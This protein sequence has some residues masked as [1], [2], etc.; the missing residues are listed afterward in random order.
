MEIISVYFALLSIVSIFIFYLL[1]YKYRIGFLAI[2][3]CSFIASIDYL[4]LLYIII[5][6]LINYFIGIKLPNSKYKV[7]L[8]RT[9]IIVNLSQLILL[10]YASFTV[11]PL[12]RLFNNNIQ[13]SKLT[14]ILVPIGISYFTLQG[15]GYLINIKRGWEKPEKKLLDFLLY[16]TFFPKFLSGPIE[17]SNHFLPQLKSAISFNE[18]QVSEGLKIALFGFFKKVVIANQLGRIVFLAHSDPDSF[19]LPELWLVVLIQPLYLYFDF[20]GYTDIARGFAKTFGIDLL[21]NF[22]KPFL[23]ENMTGFWKRFHMSL[24]AWFNDYVFNPISFKF[25]RWGKSAAVFALFVS[26][27]LFGI[28]HGAGWNFMAL[29]LAQAL[30]I[31]YEFFTKRIRSELGSKIPAFLRVMMSRIITFIFYGLS[32][33][34]FFSRDLNSSLHFFSQLTDLSP[35]SNTKHL[36]NLLFFAL[37]LSFIFL[38]IDYLKQD[39]TEINNRIEKI[40][41]SSR[42]F[43]LSV[44]YAVAFLIL[45]FIGNKLTFVYQ[46]F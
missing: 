5:Y 43:R 33:I 45:V 44:Y 2:L 27:T 39:H 24:S 40:F 21:P 26:W 38:L 20:S 29:G 18:Q 9:G 32:L 6:S 37:G 14:E 34:F 42:I 41:S 28:W 4:L 16:I 3:S 10:K 46:V 25:R 19:S 15:I 1:N 23:A 30:G 17:R 31:I 22:N 8:F 35:W 11:D 36:N 12:I 13:F 7:L